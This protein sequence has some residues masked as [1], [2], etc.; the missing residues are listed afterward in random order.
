MSRA[1]YVTKTAVIA[2]GET[3]S[4]LI[5]F[6][7]YTAGGF[8]LPDTFTG[9]AVSFL[10]SF[11]GVNF[12]P[13]LDSTG[14]EI[15]L[16]VVAGAAYMLPVGTF[17][18]ACMKVVAATNQGADCEVGIALKYF[19]STFGLGDPLGSEGGGI[20]VSSLLD[21]LEAAYEFEDSLIDL[22]GNGHDLTDRSGG[23][24][25]AFVDGLIGRAARFAS[26]QHNFLFCESTPAIFPGQDFTIAVEFKPTALEDNT[27][28]PY[29][30]ALTGGDIG[31]DQWVMAIDQ[32]AFPIGNPTPCAV[33]QVTYPDM[34]AETI[35]D[36]NWYFLIGWKEGNKVY[37]Q[38]NGGTI[39]QADAPDPYVLSDTGMGLVIGNFDLI[40]AHYE[41]GWLG[42]DY[43]GDVG[44]AFY[45]PERAITVDERAEIWNSGSRKQYPFS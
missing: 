35:A 13:L 17:P 22:T 26:A 31:I 5:A 16:S 2:S 41:F 20:I 4:E 9:V 42:F 34:T 18:F 23:T 36:D 39:F 11:D 28:T 33:M 40:A 21:G 37:H 45:W 12:T 24:P 15:V 3:E 27:V 38:I 32:N 1:Y 10:V 7:D 14:T 44:C 29:V 8:T 25:V 6:G 43:S 19:E 30:F